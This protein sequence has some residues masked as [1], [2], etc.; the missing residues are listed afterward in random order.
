MSNTSNNIERGNYEGYLW[1][2]DAD[3]PVVL[4][5]EELAVDFDQVL[6][7]EGKDYDL[8]SKKVFIVEAQLFDNN[9]KIS[10][11][12]KYVDGKHL[13]KRYEVDKKYLEKQN[14]ID[15]LSD[16][17]EKPD[18][19]QYYG[20]RLKRWLKF[21]QYWKLQKDSFC[22]GMETWIPKQLVFVGF[23]NQKEVHNG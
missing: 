10:Y 22:C 2:S 14:E 13:V 11:S 15:A 1:F 12:V 3:A 20:N 19:K 6:T 5:G 21:L 4:D 7:I 16:N 8:P 17:P 23:N 18:Y 9:S